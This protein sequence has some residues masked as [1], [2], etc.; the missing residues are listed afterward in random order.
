MESEDGVGFFFSV[1]RGA[2]DGTQG[3]ASTRTGT[4]PCWCRTTLLEAFLLEGE[5]TCL[6]IFLCDNTGVFKKIDYHAVN[7]FAF[8]KQ[9]SFYLSHTSSPFCFGYFGDGISRTICPGWPLPSVLS[10]SASQIVRITG[11]SHW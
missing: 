3:P 8:P 1:F 9:V 4:A 5:I 7:N 6:Q 2:G 10:F 11:M